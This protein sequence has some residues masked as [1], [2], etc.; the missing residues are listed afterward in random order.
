MAK[1][2]GGGPGRDPRFQANCGDHSISEARWLQQGDKF[3]HA[4]VGHRLHQGCPSDC[5]ASPRELPRSQPGG[6]DRLGC[7]ED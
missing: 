2:T 6:A 4:A 7:F 3:H 1:S 5:E